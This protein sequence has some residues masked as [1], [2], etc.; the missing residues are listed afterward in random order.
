M[1]AVVG[2]KMSLGPSRCQDPVVDGLIEGSED[3]LVI[4]AEKVTVIGAIAPTADVPLAGVIEMTERRE[5]AGDLVSELRDQD[6]VRMVL[7]VT[8]ILASPCG[9]VAGRAIALMPS[10]KLTMIA[11]RRLPTTNTRRDLA[12][13][14]GL[15]F[16]PGSPFARIAAREAAPVTRLY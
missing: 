5:V 9:D 12:A 15:P 2:V 4:A 3:P 13:T 14:I 10:P 16:F 1:N 7:V 8:A 11:T 6:E